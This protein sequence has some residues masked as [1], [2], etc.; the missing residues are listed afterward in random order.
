MIISNLY[1]CDFSEIESSYDLYI[2]VAGKE[3]RSYYLATNT[4]I[5]KLAK[6]K[7][8]IPYL[9]T[10]EK[11][12]DYPKD[13]EWINNAHDIA[14]PIWCIV[15]D[16]LVK[17]K[18]CL[19]IIIDYSSM[20][21]LLY[22]SFLKSCFEYSGK[23]KIKLCFIYN[24]AKP[25]PPPETQSFHFEPMPDY[26]RIRLPQNPTALIIGL[27][28]EE[29]RAYSLKDYFDAEVVNVFRTDKRSS[30]DYYELVDKNNDRLL[31]Q[32]ALSESSL[33]F[34][35]SLDN[36][37][38]THKVLSNLCQDLSEHYRVVIAPCGPKPFT[39]ISLLVA[40]RLGSVDVWRVHNVD[41]VVEKEASEQN[42]VTI[43]EMIPE[44]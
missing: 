2:G 21:R 39:L 16:F 32:I 30:V 5:I 40:L 28:Y 11:P 27:G 22:G 4:N 14:N 6:N 17:E 24:V 26:C 20:S 15:E 38:Y 9:E 19:S 8:V 18:D 7:Y 44:Q 43:V 12:C 10:T 29:G 23:T 13:I 1:N 37:D 31:R 34:E 36:I 42:I 25:S 3:P 33:I 41:K 35:Y